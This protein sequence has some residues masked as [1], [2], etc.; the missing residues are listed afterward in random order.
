MA[1][2]VTAPVICHIAVTSQIGSEISITKIRR[3][4]GERASGVVLQSLRSDAEITKEFRPLR[5]SAQVIRRFTCEASKLAAGWD[6]QSVVER[7]A[8]LK[9]VVHRIVVDGHDVSIEVSHQGLVKTLIARN[10]EIEPVERLQQL[11]GRTRISVRTE[12]KRCRGEVR[13]IAP[14]EDPNDRQPQLDPALIK[15]TARAHIWREHLFSGRAT[16]ISDIA[17]MAGVSPRYVRTILN[18]TYLA[19]RLVEAILAG[20]Q[21]ID[22]TLDQLCAGL[23]S[24]WRAQEQRF[25]VTARHQT[26]ANAGNHRN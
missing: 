7:I 11:Q 22:L 23:P 16:T 9:L 21:P 18:L 13:L 6:H 20:R 8:L 24:D 15:A 19:P 1:R 14:D 17:H 26:P 10:K 5:L 25:E 3:G 12:I 4:L 2:Y